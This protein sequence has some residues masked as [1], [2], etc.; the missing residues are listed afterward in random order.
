[1]R[2]NV[3]F[4]ARFCRSAIRWGRLM[5]RVDQRLELL[6]EAIGLA[7]RLL[8]V[9]PVHYREDKAELL[10]AYAQNAWWAGLRPADAQLAADE[11]AA[12]FGLLAEAGTETHHRDR[13]AACQKLRADITA[14]RRASGSR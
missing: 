7:D 13:W 2:D 14:D 1:M 10:Y 3:Y 11:A 5:P 12:H 4:Q 8:R 9:N 6:H